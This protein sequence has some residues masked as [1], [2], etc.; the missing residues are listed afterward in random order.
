MVEEKDLEM[1][2]DLETGLERALEKARELEGVLRDVGEAVRS[3]ELTEL[4]DALEQSFEAADSLAGKLD[5]I[6]LLRNNVPSPD[7]LG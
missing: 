4:S 2:N 1:L 6:G 7:E 3:L 5:D